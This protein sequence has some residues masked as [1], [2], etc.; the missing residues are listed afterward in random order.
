[1]SG[2]ELNV[3]YI[4]GLLGRV[5]ELHATYYARHWN[6]GQYFES[7]VATEMAGFLERYNPAL[8]CTWTLCIDGRIEGSITVDGSGEPPGLAHVRWFIMS[9]AL[10]GQ[11]AGNR[12]MQEVMTFCQQSGFEQVYLWTFAGLESAHHLYKKHGF[13]L[14]E[15][16]AGAQW[17]TEVTEQRFDRR[18]QENA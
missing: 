15:S 7:K 6:F 3:G 11:G 13:T 18:L 16:R 9:D 5:A 4:P 10:R 1:M 17:G 12:L 2:T 14:T 8:D